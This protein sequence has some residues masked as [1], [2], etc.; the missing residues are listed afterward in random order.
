[1]NVVVMQDAAGGTYFE[2]AEVRCGP[3]ATSMFITMVPPSGASWSITA[4]SSD[5]SVNWNTNNAADLPLG[6]YTVHVTA[7]DSSKSGTSTIRV[8][9]GF[10]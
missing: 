3:G 1:M 9:G 7:S 5:P 10:V 6:S 8:T 4:V 2:P